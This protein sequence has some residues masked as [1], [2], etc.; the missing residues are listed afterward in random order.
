MLR[1]NMHRF[2]ST[3][4]NQILCVKC[5]DGDTLYTSVT[6]ATTLF[7]TPGWSQIRT[8]NIPLGPPDDLIYRNYHG[9]LANLRIINLLFHL[10]I[11]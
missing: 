2:D 10:H 5:I 6:S 4:T 9:Y 3:E 8:T 11:I 7:I 1:K